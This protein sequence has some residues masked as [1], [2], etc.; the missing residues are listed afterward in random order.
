MSQE[1]WEKFTRRINEKGSLE[2]LIKN[3]NIFAYMSWLKVE[4]GK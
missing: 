2:L 3:G 4:I 1:T